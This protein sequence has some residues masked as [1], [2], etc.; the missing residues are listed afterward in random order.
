MPNSN[1]PQNTIPSYMEAISE[2]Y[3]G[4]IVDA[5]IAKI[6]I[7]KFIRTCPTTSGKSIAVYGSFAGTHGPKRKVWVVTDPSQDAPR[8]YELKAWIIHNTRKEI[9]FCIP[10]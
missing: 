3:F 1:I 10:K 9:T 2:S 5:W 6:A 4:Y 7:K 8:G